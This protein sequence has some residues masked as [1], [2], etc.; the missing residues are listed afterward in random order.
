MLA[1]YRAQDWRGARIA[2]AES[3]SGNAALAGFYELYAER[4]THFEANP[5]GYDWDGIFV[6]ETK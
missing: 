5:P 1:C 2:L 3:R 6:S 4:I